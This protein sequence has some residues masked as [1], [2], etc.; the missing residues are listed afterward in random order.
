MRRA[1]TPSAH[2]SLSALRASDGDSLAHCCVSCDRLV[3]SSFG[4]LGWKGATVPLSFLGFTFFV[5][6]L[7]CLGFFNFNAEADPASKYTPYNS[8]VFRQRDAIAAAGFVHAEPRITRVI[9]QHPSLDEQDVMTPANLYALFDVRDA[10][11][12][13]TVAVGGV[14]YGFHDLCERGTALGALGRTNT[15]SALADECALQGATDVWSN[16]RATLL[17][18]SS[19]YTRLFDATTVVRDTSGR[20]VRSV[21]VVSSRTYAP[22]T[23]L[24]AAGYQFT[25]SL[26]N[27]FDNGGGKTDVT[28]PS[29]DAIAA[30]WEKQLR[31][32]LQ[33]LTYNAFPAASQAAQTSGATYS[34]QFDG[35]RV[36]VLSPELVRSEQESAERFDESPLIA[37]Y[38]LVWLFVAACFARRNFVRSRMGLSIASI[39]TVA[40]A[41]ASSVGACAGLGLRFHS[42]LVLLSFFLLAVG[43]GDSF[44]LV[45]CIQPFEPSWRQATPF[46]LSMLASKV[47]SRFWWIRAAEE[48]G[49]EPINRTQHRRRGGQRNGDDEEEDDAAAMGEGD[50]TVEGGISVGT[51]AAGPLL[52]T[53]ALAITCS[54]LLGAYTSI[55]A[56]RSFCLHASLGVIFLA[57]FHFTFFI[58]LVTIDAHRQN[59]HRCDT[60]LCCCPPVEESAV[61][62]QLCTQKEVFDEKSDTHTMRDKCSV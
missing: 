17:A 28:K 57:I 38:F 18:D 32:N 50:E 19:I 13:A 36:W 8:H 39:A 56:F 12:A 51:A 11:F 35:F 55:P 20:T 24:G 23:T 41:L 30:A 42:D 9:L 60:P 53:S 1:R 54:L 62:H 22:A 15:S 29:V 31:Y 45:A 48:D 44:V 58:P 4:W 47:Q 33:H 6:T 46:A 27:R 61:E 3:S 21:D 26:V 59:A 7:C 49:V 25:L 40:L 2:A 34:T 5:A 37:G 10:I 14:T 16:N 52:A 43:L